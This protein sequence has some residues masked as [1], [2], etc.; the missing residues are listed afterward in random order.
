MPAD[1]KAD[2]K[3]LL[4][5]V[6]KKNASD[7]HISVGVPPAMRIDGKLSYINEIGNLTEHDVERTLLTILT[8]E[9]MKN[10]RKNLELDFSFSFKDASGLE[11]RFRGNC[12][13]ESRKM[14]AAFRLIP[15]NIR[16]IDDLRL[17][18]VLKEISKK[19]RGLFL[20]TG[21]TGHGKTTTLASIINEINKCIK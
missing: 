8:E 2:L 20:V 11:A 7:L 14:A 16:S 3:A 6:I 19:R 1:S 15:V 4:G 12:Y 18:P 21:P 5:D 9:Q 13:H 17:P 10:Y